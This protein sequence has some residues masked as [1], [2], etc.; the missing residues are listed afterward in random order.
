MERQILNKEL[1]HSKE[2]IEVLRFENIELAM[3]NVNLEKENKILKERIK[4][5]DMMLN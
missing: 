2:K 3:K 1:K 4:M 5:L